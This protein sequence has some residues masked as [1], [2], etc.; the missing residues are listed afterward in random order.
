MLLVTGLYKY[1]IYLDTLLA[2]INGHMNSVEIS[3][4]WSALLVYYITMAF[5]QVT[6]FVGGS[7]PM[8]TRVFNGAKHNLITSFC[9]FFP[10][11]AVFCRVGDKG[12]CVGGCSN[13]VL[14]CILVRT[15]FSFTCR[16]AGCY[17]GRSP[18][19]DGDMRD[20]T[21]GGLLLHLQTCGMLR[22]EIFSCTCRHAG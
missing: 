3:Q 8:K 16:H 11:P 9:P 1:R 10:L 20:V 22:R 17:A 5:G 15:S 21:L 14:L 19:A 18:L 12:G 6:L 7:D 13:V 2:I 4:S